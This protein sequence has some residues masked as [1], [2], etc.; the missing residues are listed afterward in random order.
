MAAKVLRPL[1]ARLSR[2]QV[3]EEVV[4]LLDVGAMKVSVHLRRDHPERSIS[5]LQIERCLRLRSVQADP[6]VNRF[7]NWQAEMFRHM[8]GSEL[9]VVA[10]I[11][12][13]ECVIVITAYEP[14]GGRMR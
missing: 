4:R 2:R 8:A 3:R 14:S 7:G 12:W 10:A 5:H 1:P 9:T 11:E 13:E 6:Y